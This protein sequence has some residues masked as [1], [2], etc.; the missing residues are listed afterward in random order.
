[1][2]KHENTIHIIRALPLLHFLQGD[3]K[4]HGILDISTR[5]IK[6]GEPSLYMT[7]LRKTMEGKSG[8]ACVCCLCDV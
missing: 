5:H 4:P 6:W 3:S 8:Y 1:M 7:T 2:K